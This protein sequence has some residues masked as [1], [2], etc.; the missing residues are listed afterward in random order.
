M[1]RKIRERPSPGRQ[2]LRRGIPA[3]FICALSLLSGAA[4]APAQG[5]D[6][7]RFTLRGF[8][9]VS[10]TTHDADGIEFRRNVGQAH[11]V[12][13]GKVDFGV[14]S[15]AGV[16]VDVT[17]SSK[18]GMVMQGVS[19]MR[20]DGDWALRL[21][22]GYIRYSPDDSLVL[23]AGRVGYDIY[24]LAE[25]R[26]VGY[27]YLAVRPSPE[28]YGQ[29][30]DDQI[31]GGDVSYTRRMGPGLFRARV[32]GG[33]GSGEMAFADGTHSDSEGEIFG[34]TLDYIYRGW[35][36]RVALVQ[37][38]YK[39]GPEL[40][41]LAAGLQMTG[42]PSALAIAEGFNRDAL[43]SLGVQVG[44]AY[45]DGPM[46][47]Q[48][49]YGAANSDS[50]A[51]PNFDKSYALFGYRLRK[52]TPFVSYA[53]SFDRDPVIDAGLPDLPMLAPL[54][55]AVRAVQERT[56]S[57]QHTT[58]LGVRYDFSSRVAFK[59]QLDRTRA[60]DSTLNFDFRSPSGVAAE[61][62]D[63]TV[64]AATVDFVF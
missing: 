26:Q 34:A 50:L 43:K 2:S 3:T 61:P 14:D 48:L 33:E 27:S 44:I 41:Q 30:T 55:A 18:L 11:G 52:W 22:Q 32:F 35:T 53:A 54:N 42:F 24:L 36:S 16:Q 49:M 28:F 60:S 4:A 47:A 6:V 25:S 21:A 20:A 38:E 59:L 63:M 8:G 39:V 29:I 9:T 10:A 51:G 58:S 37:F 31:D 57:T 15:I 17:L 1:E 45:D 62:Y 12:E 7:D 46:L 40:G 19:R 64:T 5:I 13:A 56:R 23:R